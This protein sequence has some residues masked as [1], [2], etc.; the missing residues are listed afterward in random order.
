MLRLP[1]EG[2]PRLKWTRLV[3][4]V[5]LAAVVLVSY[6]PSVKVGFLGDDWW[7]LGKAASLNLPDYLAFYFDPRTQIFWYRP[8]YGIFLLFEY[9]FFGAAP[10]GYHVG[11]IVLHVLNCLLLF[12]IV[13]QFTGRWRIA[14]L[15][16][17]VFAVLPVNN[18]AI[19]WIA[20]QDPLA[21]VFYLAS[22]WSWIVYLQTERRAYYFLS[23]AAFVLALLG[24]ESSVFLPITLFL[25]DRLLIAKPSSL[26][27][28]LRRYV[29]IAVVFL[30]Y[31]A[32]ELRVQTYAY[33]PNHWGYGIGEQIIDNLVHY[34]SLT[35][36]PWGEDLPVISYSVLALALL[37]L[38]PFGIWKRSKWLVFFAIQ[39]ALAIAPA[40]A[41]PTQ[42]FQAR[43]LYVAA[44]L[45]AILLASLVETIWMH[46][47]NHRW[48]VAAC[49]LAALGL[50]L[51]GSWMTAAASDKQAE[52]ARQN[53]V[54]I[55]DIF[56][57]HPDY[58]AGTY[59]YF[60]EPPY[61]MIMRNLTGMFF[62]RY[63]PKVTVWSNDAERG[64]I[65]EN[66]FAQLR[67]HARSFVYYFDES[68]RRHEVAVD[69]TAKNTAS[70]AL[71]AQFQEGIRLEGFELTGTTL[72][73]G[74]DL[75]LLLYWRTTDTIQKDY[76]VF[77]HWVNDKGEIILGDDTQPRGGRAPTSGWAVNKLVVDTHLITMPSDALPGKY[78]LE[79]GLYFLP[80]QQRLQV[81]DD[82]GNPV[83]DQVSIEP[84]TIVD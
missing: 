84:F 36:F 26:S 52:A 70:P 13:R 16:G 64:G 75:V 66:R 45:S 5:A 82:H 79:V 12:G 47:G 38:I 18:L 50:V 62:L 69:M 30:A 39:T 59:L 24:K 55:R 21:M 67:D 6:L 76:T 34:L 40:L 25:I 22:I 46:L 48:K 78:H 51:V 15:A 4:L 60:V 2:Y 80:T 28:A 42:F 23:L 11:Q 32:I 10:D 81:I 65:D 77:V 7:F 37:V 56:Q 68:L 31:L 74:N 33:F 58:P 61:P 83:V 53:R 9:L 35:I 1:P 54:P 49:A 73:P 14:L 27:D 8:L 63:G 17:L 57:E 20:V 3:G 19:F 41:F 71:P 72:K 29:P 44:A 43:Y